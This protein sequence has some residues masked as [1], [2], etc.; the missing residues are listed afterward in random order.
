MHAQ[1]GPEKRSVCPV[2]GARRRD[3]TACSR[4]T[5]S[6]TPLI[7]LETRAACLRAEA[8]RCLERGAYAQAQ[9]AVARAQVLCQTEMGWALEALLAMFVNVTPLSNRTPPSLGKYTASL[10]SVITGTCAWDVLG[11]GISENSCEYRRDEKGAL[12]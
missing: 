6:F 5:A 7:T 10:M 2:C 4:C 9:Q 12:L 8:R 11:Y 3:A 1:E